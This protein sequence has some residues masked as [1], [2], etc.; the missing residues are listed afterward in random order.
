M[1]I[2]IESLLTKYKINYRTSGPQVTSGWVN[3]RCP[4]CGDAGEHLGYSPKLDLF[5]CW[6]CGVK[7]KW[8]VISKLLNASE[9]KVTA[10][11]D[12]F[13]KVGNDNE[14]FVKMS[15]T[16]Q[17]PENERKLLPSH[18]RYINGRGFDPDYLEKTWGLVSCGNYG[19]YRNRIIIPIYY[20]G[21][22]VS[23]HSRSIK[24]NTEIKAKACPQQDEVIRH[25]ELLYGFDRVPGNTV[26]VSEAPFDK[27]RWGDEGVATFGIKWTEHQVAL[28]SCFSNIFLIFD[29]N[30]VDGIEK[31][32]T[33]QK[34]AEELSDRLAIWN[35][36]WLI[37]D[38]GCDPADLSQRRANRIKQ[39]FLDIVKNNQKNVR[40]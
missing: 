5:T 25:K 1:A 26:I 27:W 19:N 34:Q 40:Y 15:E 38:L 3:I 24:S 31:E 17:L 9:D 32:K 21:R 36:V 11:L 10:V 23:F 16:C 20:D 33:A 2:D 18:K 8:R 30:I 37:T 39:G 28:L 4:F 12:E 6:R 7:N 35:K 22:L 14:K 13:Y 29:S